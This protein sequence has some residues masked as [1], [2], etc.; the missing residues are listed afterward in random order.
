[1]SKNLTCLHP[2]PGHSGGDVEGSIVVAACVVGIVDEEGMP[3]VIGVLVGA[4]V[5]SG[6]LGWLMS[7]PIHAGKRDNSD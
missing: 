3:A 6:Q 2:S 4:V 7:K 1:M 5:G